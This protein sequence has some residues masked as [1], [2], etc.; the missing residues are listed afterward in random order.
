MKIFESEFHVRHFSHLPDTSYSIVAT[1]VGDT[2]SVCTTA[3]LPS[4]GWRDSRIARYDC[5]LFA[6]FISS[7]ERREKNDFANNIFNKGFTFREIEHLTCTC[8]LL[9]CN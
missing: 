3:K 5:M 8:V 7:A 2:H 4:I 1:C 6:I 9:F